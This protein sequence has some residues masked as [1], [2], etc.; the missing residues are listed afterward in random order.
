VG[1][2]C[3]G[4]ASRGTA[5]GAGRHAEAAQKVLHLGRDAL[6]AALGGGGGFIVVAVGAVH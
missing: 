2:S 1:S 3:A 5:E 6:R 4:A